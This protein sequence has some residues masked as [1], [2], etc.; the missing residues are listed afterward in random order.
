[1]PLNFNSFNATAPVNGFRSTVPDYQ[2]FDYTNAIQGFQQ[3]AQQ[4]PALGLAT[5]QQQ[6]DLYQQFQDQANGRGVNLAQTLLQQQIQRNRNAAA[7]QLGSIRG[8]NPA[9]A[10]RL[11]LQQSGL[12]NTQAAGQGAVL[13]QQQQLAAQQQEAQL[14]GA[15]RAQDIAQQQAATAAYGVAGGLGQGQGSL[16]VQA[17][18]G[19]QQINAGVAGQNAAN[20]LGAQ[21]IN[22][23]AASQNAGYNAAISGGLLGGVGAAN[24]QGAASGADSGYDTDTWNT[25]GGLAH[26]GDVNYQGGGTVGGKA[27]VAGDSTRND[28]V[29]AMLSPHEIVLP[30]SVTLA[31]DAPERAKAFVQAIMASKQHG[32]SFP[33]AAYD[34][35]LTKNR[36]SA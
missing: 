21:Q 19:S 29:H 25:E 20:Q 10:Q 6:G 22:A 2:N 13:Q 14:L 28:V 31:P 7:S 8:M 32:D 5:G 16:G 18:L 3:Q 17:G 35:M 11:L 12:A 15:K 34:R 30:R 4:A 33:H 23:G 24:A 36:K 26:G 1:M 9:L 27:K